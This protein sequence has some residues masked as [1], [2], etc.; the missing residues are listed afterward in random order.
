MSLE[1]CSSYRHPRTTF[2]Y[3]HIQK[4]STDP[5]PSTAA[6]ISQ[7]SPEDQPVQCTPSDPTI[8]HRAFDP[9][10]QLIPTRLRRIW[11]APSHSRAAREQK[12]H[13]SAALTSPDVA[14]TWQKKSKKSRD[15]KPPNPWNARIMIT[16]TDNKPFLQA[17]N[18]KAQP[19]KSQKAMLSDCRR[20]LTRRWGRQRRGRAR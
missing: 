20:P 16:Q 11:T 15:S 19:R 9:F 7:A 2:I 5:T 18:C 13:Y 6:S 4:L 14:R 17:S 8:G 3:C 10:K 12:R 1:A